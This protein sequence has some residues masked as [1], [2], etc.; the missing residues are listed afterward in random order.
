MVM[1]C[2]TQELDLTRDSTEATLEG[3]TYDGTPIVG[4]D[5]VNMVPKGK[6]NG[7]K[8]KKKKKK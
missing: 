4:T 5:S 6:G 3:E 7:K 1:H 8:A 2:K